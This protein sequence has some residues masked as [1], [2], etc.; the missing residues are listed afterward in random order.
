MDTAVAGEPELLRTM[1]DNLVR[2]AIRFSP[3][4]ERVEVEASV[5][6]DR[7]KIRVR[8]YGPGIPAAQ[9]ATIFDRFAQAPEEQ[10]KGRGH[11]LGLAIALGIAELHGGSISAENCEDRG[12]TFV[13][14]L[15]QFRPGAKGVGPATG[16]E[17]SR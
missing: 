12:C 9:L 13:V 4:D 5:V 16:T 15:P 14:E 3:T 7:V 17:T 6:G 8:D 10:R 11:G 1:L 2:N